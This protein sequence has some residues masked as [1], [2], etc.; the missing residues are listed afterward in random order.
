MGKFENFKS[1]QE[2]VGRIEQLRADGVADDAITVFS[3]EALEGN[4]LNYTDVNFK[5]ADGSAWDKFVS[6]F[7][8]EE[9]EERALSN[10][11]LNES[12]KNDYI[13]SLQAGDI[14]LHVE[15]RAGGASAENMDYDDE[16]NMRSDSDDDNVGGERHD[17]EYRNE[18]DNPGAVDTSNQKDAASVGTGSEL[19][20]GG[21]SVAASQDN[22]SVE[23]SVGEDIEKDTTPSDEMDQD[24]SSSMDVP[25]DVDVERNADE[26]TREA[27]HRREDHER[28]QKMRD[29]EVGSESQFSDVGSGRSESTD[30]SDEEHEDKDFEGTMRA[31]DEGSDKEIRDEDIV[32]DARLTDEEPNFQYATEETAETLDVSTYGYDDTTTRD[33]IRTSSDE[34]NALK[35]SD[36]SDD[37]SSDN[38]DDVDDTDRD[39]DRV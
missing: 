8:S 11:D 12:E 2:L 10:L 13:T 5:S 17:A 25:K 30:N 31:D 19:S 38:N 14:L 26:S 9:P 28:D 6:L 7:T 15:K 22:E 34:G 4:S 29:D 32:E 33:D 39:K 1:E 21:R 23:D 36:L 35:E 3:K 16:D 27:E 37:R 18:E 20:A 24:R